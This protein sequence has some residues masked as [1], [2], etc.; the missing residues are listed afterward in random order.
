MHRPEQRWKWCSNS[1]WNSAHTFCF[2][3]VFDAL[4]MD[5]ACS[6]LEDCNELKYSVK[7]SSTMFWFHDSRVSWTMMQTKVIYKRQII[8]TLVEAFSS[9]GANLSL[10]FGFSFLTLVES[11]FFFY[12]GFK[13]RIQ[14]Y[15]LEKAEKTVKRG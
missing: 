3:A 8:H 15:L 1:L 9:S 4:E 5:S 7:A 6:C 14:R 11:I 12:L 13:I 2:T 10:F